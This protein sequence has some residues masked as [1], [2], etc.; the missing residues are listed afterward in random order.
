MGEI[1]NLRRARKAKVRDAAAWTAAEN[2][3]L[4][5]QS[6]QA[7]DTARQETMRAIHRHEDHRL[8]EE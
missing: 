1:V 7:R 5:G 4:H 6:K 8:D 3:A 2:R